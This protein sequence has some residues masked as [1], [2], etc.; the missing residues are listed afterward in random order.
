M[1]RRR[2]HANATARSPPPNFLPESANLERVSGVS[3][4][5]RVRFFRPTLR[6]KLRPAPAPP[7]RCACQ[8]IRHLQ[9][10][11]TPP[12]SPPRSTAQIGSSST[13][14]SPR[15]HRDTQSPRK[16]NHPA[17][18][19]LRLRAPPPSPPPKHSHPSSPPPHSTP[20]TTAHP[21]N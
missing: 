18:R 21:P 3:P 9:D 15:K 8:R 1:R 11:R 19:G 12:P 6:S 20:P 13:P 16:H 14:P 17:H 4:K 10:R 7:R 2:N 5:C